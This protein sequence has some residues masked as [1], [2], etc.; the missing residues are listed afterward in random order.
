MIYKFTF[1]GD[2]PSKKNSRII[3]CFGR[4]P[5]SLPGKA[6]NNWHNYMKK[7]SSNFDKP[8]EIITS[9]IEVEITIYPRTKRKFDI[10]NKIESIM[11][12]LVDIKIIEDDNWSIVKS[13]TGN[14]GGVDIANPRAEVIIKV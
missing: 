12:F 8:A 6:Y 10:S 7:M 9:E 14:F 3:V 4:K 2:V 11:D 13:I 1:P 5:I